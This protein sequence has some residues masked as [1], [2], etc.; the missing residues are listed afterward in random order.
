MNSA[1]LGMGITGQSIARYLRTAGEDCRCFDEV[2]NEQMTADVVV[3]RFDASLLSTFDRVVVSPGIIWNHPA[4]LA[5]RSHA[6][7]TG[8]PDLVSDL[9]L[10]V[11]C[12]QGDLMV[13]TGTNGKTTVTHLLGVLLETLAGGVEVGGNIGQPMLDLLSGAHRSPRVVL[14]LSSFQLERSRPPHACWSALLNIQQDHVD[15]HG[16]AADYRAAKESVFANQGEGDH[17]LLPMDADFDAL[18]NRLKEQGVVV[19]RFGDDASVPLGVNMAVNRDVD[20]GICEDQLCWQSAQGDVCRVALSELKIH[21]RHQQC[22]L[23][24]AAQGAADCGVHDAVIV[25][26]VTSFRGLPHRLQWVANQGGYDWFNDSKATNPDSASAALMALGSTVW[27]CGGLTKGVDLTSLQ[28]VVAKHVSLMVVI[29]N[30]PAPFIALAK[31]S[32]VAWEVAASMEQAVTIAAQK[33]Q[34]LPVLLSPAAASF[35]QFANYVDRGNAF[36]Q[37]VRALLNE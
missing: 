13:V 15:M 14:E 28:A 27:I 32:A 19:R 23:A 35:D 24:V 1:I 18:A 33:G 29:G 20:V 31:Q 7:Q 30:D 17:A 36:V 2:G 11:A 9:D 16:S 21:G 34:A 25:E 26:G 8:K 37:A 4:L 5:L 12:Y 6:E 3:G 10:F 22:N